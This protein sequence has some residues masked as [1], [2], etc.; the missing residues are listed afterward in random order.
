MRMTVSEPDNTWRLLPQP[1]PQKFPM[2]MIHHRCPSY[3]LHLHHLGL[4][5]AAAASPEKV[6]C[7]PREPERTTWYLRCLQCPP[8]PRPTRRKRQWAEWAA[9][10]AVGWGTATA[11]PQGLPHL[12]ST[13]WAMSPMKV[14][15]KKRSSYILQPMGWH[16]AVGPHCL[17]RSWAQMRMPLILT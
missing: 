12:L 7:K 8:N 17:Q 3:H 13:R 16:R 6:F 5:S 15:K 1:Q 11:L 4:W 2:V 10:G 9:V 14:R